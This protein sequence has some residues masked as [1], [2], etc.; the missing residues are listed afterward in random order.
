M[1]GG[2]DPV[3]QIS[4]GRDGSAVLKCRFVGGKGKPCP[5]ADIWKSIGLQAPRLE[6][7]LAA[8]AASVPEPVVQT[9]PAGNGFSA[10]PVGLRQSQT[11]ECPI[12]PDHGEPTG[13]MNLAAP[14]LAPPPPEKA[15]PDEIALAGGDSRAACTQEPVADQPVS[16]P[17]AAADSPEEAPPVAEVPTLLP[18]RTPEEAMP[19][20]TAVAEAGVVSSEA[21]TRG[22]AADQAASDRNP[23]AAADSPEEAPPVAEAPPRAPGRAPARARKERKAAHVKQARA[24]MLRRLGEEIRLVRG[25]DHRVF[26]EVPNNGHHEVHELESTGFLKWLNLY[27][28]RC[29]MATPTTHRHKSLIRA[30]GADAAALVKG[31]AVWVRVAGATTSATAAAHSLADGRQSGGV[32]DDSAAAPAG[33]R[34]PGQVASGALFTERKAII[35]PTIHLDLGDSTRQ[36]VEIRAGGWR[37]VDRSGVLFSRPEGFRSDA[38]AAAGRLDRSAQEICQCHRRRFPAAGRVDD[39]RSPAGRAVSHPGDQRRAGL[40]QEHPGP[41]DS[42]AD[43]SQRI[44]LGGLPASEHDFMIQAQSAWVLMY[45][46]IRAIPDRLADAVCRIA[47]G[48]GFSTRTLYSNAG[49]TRFDVARPLLFT[50]IDDIAQ[51]S[52]LIDRCVFL[53]LPAIPDPNRRPEQEFWSEFYADYPLLLGALLDA[54]AGGLKMLPE[55]ALSA[56]PR[57]A[58]FALWGEAVHRGLGGAPGSFLERYNENRRAACE[59]QIEDNPVAEA[60]RQMAME[61]LYNETRETTATML[62][63]TLGKYASPRLVRSAQW[64]KTP[65]SL[66]VSLRRI[67]PQLR[68]IGITLNF[69]VVNNTRIITISV[70]H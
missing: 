51:S 58:D 22:L 11:V 23:P 7:A 10:E 52:D 66:A 18:P 47:T 3:L 14:A 49:E 20:G 35:A 12:S 26:A 54:V 63:R 29:G 36:C 8:S 60:M 39:R 16:D 25:L 68:A 31:E 33:E 43:R 46:N 62:L 61:E 55:T 15:A 64:P 32:R 67:A 70:S 34:V 53:Y 40:G 6:A 41:G 30:L 48:G 19:D 4:R 44:A 57:M 27:Y 2:P 24:K 13:A 21:C 65:R 17:P 59:A 28:R 50:S 45:D 42:P 5:E 38:A 37:V 9:S 56:L 69:S 1:H